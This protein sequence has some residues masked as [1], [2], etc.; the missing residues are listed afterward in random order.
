MIKIK[1]PQYLWDTRWIQEYESLTSI[2]NKFCYANGMRINHF[3]QLFKPYESFDRMDQLFGMSCKEYIKQQN[4]MIHSRI[5]TNVEGIPVF[6]DEILWYC[7]ECIKFGFHSIFHQ[8]RFFTHCIHHEN[9]QLKW[10]HRN[11]LFIGNNDYSSYKSRVYSTFEYIFTE[12]QAKRIVSVFENWR[13]HRPTN[14]TQV[15]LFMQLPKRFEQMIGKSTNK[16]YLENVLDVDSFLVA[17]RTKMSCEPLDLTK[18]ASFLTKMN[19]NQAIR[20]DQFKFGNR[21]L[22]D[23]LPESHWWKRMIRKRVATVA[24]TPKSNAIASHMKHYHRNNFMAFRC[25]FWDISN[26]LNHYVR[27]LL[28]DHRKCI[29]LPRM[30]GF[31]KSRNKCVIAE[32][33]SQMS[34]SQ[35]TM[36]TR[37]YLVYPHLLDSSTIVHRKKILNNFFRHSQYVYDA[38]LNDFHR[39]VKHTDLEIELTDNYAFHLYYEAFCQMIHQILVDKKIISNSELHPELKMISKTTGRTTKHMWL[40]QS[41]QISELVQRLFDYCAQQQACEMKYPK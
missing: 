23:G 3:N 33:F 20:L 28:I 19:I 41:V 6:D 40:Y 5:G 8:L 17:P 12:I 24:A 16:V 21:S 25:S 30:N 11:S 37:M 29:N 9:I 13:Q 36:E 2:V 38:Y 15:K 4:I 10:D 18:H 26:S 7:P 22:Y 31:R 34:S 1:Q 27:R 14:S 39:P 35:G 32:F